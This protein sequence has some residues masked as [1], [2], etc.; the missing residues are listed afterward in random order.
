MELMVELNTEQVYFTREVGHS[1]IFRCGQKFT[2]SACYLHY[3]CQSTH[4]STASTG[5]MDFS[6]ILYWGLL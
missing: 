2:K 4:I 1:P 3:V 6:E 5:W